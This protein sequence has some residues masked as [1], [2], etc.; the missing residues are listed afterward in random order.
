M[1]RDERGRPVGQV[2][3]RVNLAV[4][5]D[6]AVQ[7]KHVQYQTD[8]EL[9]PGSY[10]LKVVVRENQEGTLGTF[11]TAV[12]VP[13]LE[14][15]ALKVSSVVI[16][17][18][19]RPATS[20]SDRRNPM[21]ANGQQLLANVAHVVS[22]AQRLF[23]Y[24]EIYDPAPAGDARGPAPIRVLSNVVFFKGKQRVYETP[25]VDG[26]AVTVPERKATAFQLEVPAAGL[27]PGLYTCQVTVID[28]AGGTFAFPR[29]T[30]WVKP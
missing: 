28:D 1:L 26:Q 4:A 16:G 21:V 24:Y 9:P 11:E 14:R 20:R 29:L 7:R 18:Q 12:V 6:Q 2:R 25:L 22:G 19:L 8:F 5:T 13:N 10:R 27:Q 3:D 17:T 15:D 30:L 23:F